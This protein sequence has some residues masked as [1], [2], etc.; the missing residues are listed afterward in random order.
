M[1]TPH[2][3][4]SGGYREVASA[5]GV[6]TLTIRFDWPT[7]FPALHTRLAAFAVEHALPVTAF[8]LTHDA[9]KVTGVVLTRDPSITHGTPDRALCEQ[10][11]GALVYETG[12]RPCPTPPRDAVMVGLGLREGY[13]VHA[14]THHEREV[15]AHLAHHG[16][17]WTVQPARLLSLRPLHDGR[18]QR[19]HEPAVLIL[20]PPRLLPAITGVA[21]ALHQH[22]FVV[23]HLPE[24]RTYALRC[25]TTNTAP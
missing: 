20:A 5:E 10:A 18:V 6:W 15:R 19:H 8:C 9:A 16:R 21:A 17:G 1:T 4:T 2:S 24:N 3:D 14:I 23:H 11:G 13:S 22:R 25:T 7:T 12:W